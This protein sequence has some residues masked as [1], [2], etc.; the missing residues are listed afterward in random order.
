MNTITANAPIHK[1]ANIDAPAI[2]VVDNM[3]IAALSG[4]IHA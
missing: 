1:I 2:A 4:R 3:T